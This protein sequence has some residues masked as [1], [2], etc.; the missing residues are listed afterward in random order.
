MG[1]M[2]RMASG[3]TEWLDADQQHS[4]RAFLLGTTLLTE[5][6]GEELEEGFGISLPEYE[7]LVR[8]SEADGRVLRMAALADSLCH[9]R[10]RVTHTINRMECAG[11]VVREP[12]PDDGR[13]RQARLT[14][15][16][17]D[18]LERAAHVHVR[19]VREHLISRADRDDFA[20]LGRVMNAVTDALL[21]D[22]PEKDFRLPREGENHRSPGEPDA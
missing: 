13:G 21:G 15:A 9:S 10:S 3:D 4:W 12:S 2:R 11:L 18:L 7:V 22:Q 5:R 14:D 6:L 16:G 20:A 8:L 19:G 1:S 17:L